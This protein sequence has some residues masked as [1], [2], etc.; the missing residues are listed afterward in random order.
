MYIKKDTADFILGVSG[1]VYPNEFGG[2]LRAEKDVITEVLII[3]GTT[4]GDS[5]TSTPLYMIPIDSSII[6][7]VHSHPGSSFSP[8]RED[9]IFFG[10]TG[11]I[12]LIARYPYKSINDIAAYDR[13][14]ERIPLE[15]INK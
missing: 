13:N 2:M 3:P 4:F 11:K 8:S 14:G 7:S 10:S 9:I 1:N 6:G 5:F 12:H 15:I